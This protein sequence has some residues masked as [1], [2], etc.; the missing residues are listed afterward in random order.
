MGASNWARCARCWKRADDEKVAL[1][2]QVVASYGILPITEFDELRQRADAEI[3]LKSTFREDYE[4]YGAE[5]GWVEVSYRGKCTACG[6][7]LSFKDM[8]EIEGW[9]S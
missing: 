1:R 4:I 9:H 3:V 2:E 5:E 8:R 7:S 6:L